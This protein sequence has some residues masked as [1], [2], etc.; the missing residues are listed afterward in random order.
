[1]DISEQLYRK[2][3]QKTKRDILTVYTARWCVYSLQFEKLLQEIIDSG[4]LDDI[5]AN[6]IEIKTVL[7]Q[8]LSCKPVKDP[9]AT[10]DRK[11]Y[12]S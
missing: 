7:D 5:L 8:L 12:A 6:D 10:N 2:T 9:T 4:E 1:M 11:L 3:E